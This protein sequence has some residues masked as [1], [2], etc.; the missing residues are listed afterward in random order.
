MQDE[1]LK[2][3]RSM[4]SPCRV[5]PRRCGV[6]RLAPKG[7]GG[8]VGF[9][10]IGAAPHVASAGPHFGEEPVLVG[11]G[12][13]GTIFFQRCNL[14]CVFCQ[15]FDISHRNGGIEADADELVS[16]MSAL[17]RRG[18][19]NINFV[20]PTHVAPQVLEAII[21][22]RREGLIVPI[23]YNCGGYESVEMLSL[24]EGHIDIYMPDFKYALAA[25]GR[26]YS[27]V[28]DY[29][30]VAKAALVEMYRQVGPLTLDERGL[31]VRGVLVRH[32]VL[33]ADLAESEKVI[34]IVAETAPGCGINVMGQY[35]PCYRAD[36]FPE[37]QALPSRP[38]IARLREY[39]V[40]QG[41]MRVD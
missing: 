29:P 17:Q 21:I 39:A 13:S 9:C 34:D 7:Q 26:K 33:P 40:A 18:C 23:V 41:L 27:G 28:A 8:E 10:R 20:T 12:G 6:D 16:L 4:L 36:E 14:D 15:N 37:L 24:L 32:L 38:E 11:S 5:C 30:Q 3:A 35:H 2:R 25:A 22:A 31:A 1:M 19:D